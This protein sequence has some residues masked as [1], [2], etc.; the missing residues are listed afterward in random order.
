[1]SSLFDAL[2]IFPWAGHRLAAQL[3]AAARRRPASSGEGGLLDDDWGIGGVSWPAAPVY[4]RG[5]YRSRV[6]VLRLP[7]AAVR[8]MLPADVSLATRD[9]DGLHPLVL[10][11]GRQS[12][13]RANLWPLPGW[14]YDE[15]VVA[16]PDVQALDP[17]RTYQGPFAYLPRL[18][19]DK[20]APVLAGVLGYGFAKVLANIAA[21]ADSYSVRDAA[22]T[23]LAEARFE[24]VGQ[25]AVGQGAVGQGAPP[26][27]FPG[28]PE[29][30]R[31]LDQP[32]LAEP[33]C[34]VA[35]GSVLSFRTQ[36]VRR[37]VPLAATVTLAPGAVPQFAG[38]QFAASG[39]DGLP[40]A[41]EMESHWRITPP[42]PRGWFAP[43]AP[44]HPAPAAPEGEIAWT[45][46]RRRRIAVLGGGVGAMTAVWALTQDPD[47][48]DFY[49]IA[50]Y[51]TG[52]RLGGKGASGRNAALGQRIEEH[53][54]H[55]WAGF[56]EN[57][58]RMMRSV[59]GELGRT[60]GTPLASIDDAFKP[61]R[62][63]T[64]AETSGGVWDSFTMTIPR[65]PGLPGEGEPLVPLNPLQYLPLMIDLIGLMLP[66]AHPAVQASLHDHAARKTAWSRAAVAAAARAGHPAERGNSLLDALGA[67]AAHAQRPGAHR[68]LQLRALLAFARAAQRAT[69]QAPGGGS[70]SEKLFL[71]AI[72]LGLATMIG[73]IADGLV[74]RGFAAADGEE[75]RAWLARHGARPEAV[76]SALVR[77]TYDYVFGFAEGDTSRPA[78]AA[79]TTTH[80]VLRL[81]LTYRGAFFW[82]MQAGMGDTIFA[83]LYRV[84]QRRGVRFEY[85]H[86]VR[87]LR[88]AADGRDIG[89]IDIARQARPLD[90]A[91]YEPLVDV[92]GLESWPSAP[93]YERLEDGAALQ[94]SA[95][96]LEHA[97]GPHAELLTLRR[98]EHFDDV[99]LGISLGALP[100][101]CGE[102]IAA[103]PRWRTMIDRVKTVAT[104]GVQLWL[105]PD[106]AGLGWTQGETIA[107][108][109]AEPLDTWAAMDWLLP[110]ETWPGPVRPQSVLY[111]CGTLADAAGSGDTA[112]EAKIARDIAA[113]W[114]ANNAGAMW[115]AASDAAGALDA[116][117]LFR[118]GGGTAE[119]RFAAQYFRANTR[120]SERYVQ[121]VP[122]A[123]EA[124]L[125]PGESGFDNLWLAGDWVR[126]GMNAGCVEAGAMGGLAAASALGGRSIDIVDG[127]DVPLA[128]TLLEHAIDTV[129]GVALTD[130]LV[131]AASLDCAA[132]QGLLPDGLE[133]APQALAPDGQ[134]PVLFILARH[135]QARPNIAPFGL[136][137]RE[138]LVLLP[139]VRPKG[140]GRMFALPGPYAYVA[141]RVADSWAMLGLGRALYGEAGQY[142]RFAG[143]S[144]TG[145]RR[146][147]LLT[148]AARPQGARVRAAGA[149]HFAELDWLLAR[150]LLSRSPRGGWRL[151]RLDWRLPQ[152]SVQGLSA[153]LTAQP[154]LQ[155][156][157]PAAPWR[158]ASGEPAM[159]G[160]FR[161]WAET[162]RS[163]PLLGLRRS[164][165]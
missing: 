151:S 65:G 88:L 98:G 163:N 59:Y 7:A 17:A 8:A 68:G 93:L 16:V 42:M 105:E 14:S 10:F 76:N 13:V 148:L 165:E 28:W 132:A 62:A 46:P 35:I 139:S 140:G 131:V 56:Y 11:F 64:I 134:A 144:V 25:G 1:M 164:K 107:T 19:L 70:L 33:L 41:F 29:I 99:L 30:E 91:G 121:T 79:G 92:Q 126:S 66:Q 84:L 50:V 149:K 142:G 158:V 110:R 47:W 111:L 106:L 86:R 90:P 15:A 120:G 102:L 81:M 100:D 153:T 38:G 129:H 109:Y 150:P 156:T 146:E 117:R 137:F 5:T 77:A 21:A 40:A 147:P 89:A 101:I 4:G 24:A 39:L 60:P 95:A 44:T 124:R 83:P 20:L 133:L 58:F 94:A 123:T 57:A 67:V 74:F 12:D 55:I 112:A 115:P 69:R 3:D 22:G 71:Q 157:R 128:E 48:Q 143:D 53:G 43:A 145:R 36:E 32:L 75:W 23:L 61:H 138:L 72:D 159:L 162:A 104:L 96:D 113:G 45:K 31:L 51:Q 2:K 161:I 9:A 141:R 49:D 135:R 73:L 152:A 155:L 97:D 27:N 103:S 119:E 82:A 63:V 127:D 160:C 116:M 52:W 130:A 80:G 34:G 122:G 118:A 6:V 26:Q 87:Q 18:W 37:L 125:R 114:L 108:A 154:G 78:L 136:N 85:F 54:L